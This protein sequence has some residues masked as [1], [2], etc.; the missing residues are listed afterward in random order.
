MITFRLPRTAAASILAVTLAFLPVPG[1]A[2]PGHS[3]DHADI[4]TPGKP[5]HAV[6]TI[7][8]TMTDMAFTPPAITVKAGETVRFVVA[9]QGAVLHEFNIGTPAMHAAHRQEMA[10]LVDKGV[11]TATGLDHTKMGHGTHGGMAH[12]DPN[13]VLVEPGRTAELTWTFPRA[14][15]LEFACNV[16]GHYEAGMVGT[17]TLAN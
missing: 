10:D 8:V 7:A 5:G 11:L 9:N 2:G 14:G 15:T 6:R 16:P 4:G 13:S 3:H 12:D 17:L 1:L